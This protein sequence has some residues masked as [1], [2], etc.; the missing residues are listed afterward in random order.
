M[1]GYETRLAVNDPG[2]LFNAIYAQLRTPEKGYTARISALLAD[3]G[4]MAA[5][6]SHGLV[7]PEG[8]EGGT[9]AG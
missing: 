4:L 8:G 3:P 7:R 5:C 2:S 9:R 6:G 1:L